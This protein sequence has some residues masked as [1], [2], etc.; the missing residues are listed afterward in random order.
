MRIHEAVFAPV[1]CVRGHSQPFNFLENI[2]KLIL[3]LCTKCDGIFQTKSALN[4]HFITKHNL[5]CPSTT[6][7]GRKSVVC[8]VCGKA[9]QV[10][11]IWRSIVEFIQEAHGEVGFIVRMVARSSKNR[12]DIKKHIAA[13]HEGVRCP[14]TFCDYQSA[15][16]P[17]LDQHINVH[18]KGIQHPCSF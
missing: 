12:N 16:P 9:F 15:K 10:H 3:I 4:N 2:Y 8:D 17:D 7:T 5:M 14:C 11:I 6:Q 1:Q 13:V 18:H